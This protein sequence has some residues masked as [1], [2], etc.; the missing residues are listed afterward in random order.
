MS[1]PKQGPIKFAKPIGTPRLQQALLEFGKLIGMM[2]DAGSVNFTWF[3]S[4]HNNSL[5]G[6]ANNRDHLSFLLRALLGFPAGDPADML[7]ADLRWEP[8]TIISDKLDAGLLWNNTG[9]SMRLG[10]GGRVSLGSGKQ[11]VDL[12]LIARLLSFTP[13]GNF[14][15]QVDTEFGQFRVAGLLP[16][17]DFLDGAEIGVEIND[18][19]QQDV[20]HLGLKVTASGENTQFDVPNPEIVWD[21]ARLAILVLRAWV[22]SKNGGFFDRVNNHLFPALGDPAG[23]IQPFPLIADQPGTAPNFDLWKNSIF[24]FQNNG[25]GALTFLWHLRALITGSESTD[26]FSGSFYFP[27]VGGES[28][29]Q[30]QALPGFP[31]YQTLGEYESA[32][33]PNSVFLGVTSPGGSTHALVLDLHNP[34]GTR[35]RIE[36]AKMNGTFSRPTLPSGND[37]TDLVNFAATFN[38]AN[39]GATTIEVADEAGAIAITLATHTEPNQPPQP[40]GGDYK[41]QFLLRS[42]GAV[43]FRLKSPM[44]PAGLELP[45]NIG[46]AD[47]A[48][49]FVGLANWVLGIAGPQDPQIQIVINALMEIV[50]KAI[51]NEPP[52]PMPLLTSLLDLIGSNNLLNFGPLALNLDNNVI[53]PSLSLGP[54]KPGD[55]GDMPIHLGKLVAEA[56]VNLNTGAFDHAKVA[57][58]DLRFGEGGGAGASSG[59]VGSLLPDTRQFKGFTVAVSV[60]SGNLSIT[61][62]GKIPLQ[63]TIG[64]LDL[65]GLL[66]DL[67]TDRLLVGV[68]L[69]FKLAVITVT[70][71]E[72]GVDFP[73]NGGLPSPFLHGLGLSM[74]IPAVKLAGMFAKIQNGNQEDYVGGAVV[75][76]LSLFQLSAIGGYTQIVGDPKK[77]P[78]PSMFIFASLVAPLGG[79]PWFFI[80]GIAGGF[81]YNRTLPPPGLLTEH[82]F[83][84]VMRGDLPLGADAASSLA[85]L[86]T[87]FAAVAGQHWVAAGIQFTA[88]GFI[89]GKLVVAIA[90]GNKFAIQVLG[91]AAFGIEKIAY[92]EIGIEASANEEEFKLKAGLSK[93][94]YLVHPD[95]FSLTGEFALGVWHGG[96]HAGDFVFSIGGYHPY[97]DKP[98]HYDSLTKV[99]VRCVVYGFLRLTVECF[100]ACTPQALMAGASVSLSAE[101]A[102]IGCGL[103]VYF[104]VFIQWDPFYIRATLGIALWFE[105]FGRHEIG[106]DLQIWTPPFGGIATIDLALVSFDVDFGSELAPPPPPEPYEF[107]STH[108]QIPAERDGS[109][110]K[111]AA[112]NTDDVA[113]LF[114]VD[115]TEGRT[116]KPQA[117]TPKQEG[118]GTP[119]PM[120][121][122]FAFTVKTRLPLDKGFVVDPG[123]PALQGK[124]NLPL[125]EKFNLGTNFHVTFTNLDLSPKIDKFLKDM[126]PAADFGDK[127]TAAQSGARQAVAGVKTDQP[128]IALWDGYSLRCEAWLGAA[129]PAITAKGFEDSI[130]DEEE[131]PLPL[132]LPAGVPAPSAIANSRLTFKSGA[133]FPVIQVAGAKLSSRDQAELIIKNWKPLPLKITAWAADCQ[134]FPI[135]VRL[136]GLT[137]AAPPPDAPVIGVPSS[138]PRRVELFP[139]SL[140]I[141]TPKAT[142]DLRRR[143]LDT[144]SRA[145]NLKKSM[146]TPSTGTLTTFKTSVSVAPGTVQLLELEGSQIKGQKLTFS[147]SQAVR[148]VFLG[149]G[150]DFLSEAYVKGTAAVVPPAD[151]RQVALFGEGLYPAVGPPPA[152]TAPDAI[153]TLENVG[154][155]H[156]TT[157]TALGT[158]TLAAHG[159]VLECRTRL[160]FAVAPLDAVPG[161]EV[162]RFVKQMRLN[163]PAAGAGASL[164]ITVAPLVSNPGSAL[165]QV[166]WVGIGASLSDLTTIVGPDSTAFVMAAGAAGPWRLEIDLGKKWRLV[167]VVLMKQSGRDSVNLLRSKIERDLIDDRFQKSAETQPSAVLL[168]VTQ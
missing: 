45:P 40:F 92:F 14:P 6:I 69:S 127:V 17:P 19:A 122:E 22:A 7:G 31:G 29:Q 76:V 167:Q 99:G 143:R 58:Y 104:D 117:D 155:E 130:G 132:D 100:F 141:L 53:A 112:F 32:Q 91:L 39:A 135:G 120:A 144:L 10:V 147:G 59:I 154:I 86:G 77:D 162:L 136:R 36:I 33:H 129:P 43:A 140:R 157:L 51:R 38:G 115:F 12:A 114:R 67:R 165:D 3:M 18:P 21:C 41:L 113:G 166:R 2:D 158:R 50:G 164:V 63:E 11:H 42:G 125:C 124:I 134:R 61:G 105:F 149:A 88:F 97:F 123:V 116:T 75:R 16:V 102:G 81:G 93:N 90:F 25:E 20:F 54:F 44:A 103:D 128:S 27:I 168:E 79:P 85:S 94:S 9:N 126:F 37:W 156:D 163:F 98:K 133:N 160:P 106:V 118:I 87:Y 148:A 84:Q 47:Q 66:I 121:S 152:A 28:A 110:A 15:N 70:A 137:V 1:A 65:A 159:C 95:I 52:D 13:N 161:F 80:T 145:R 73:F 5:N 26:L 57:L 68:D 142:T 153:A 72:L 111:V 30:P 89:N 83:I 109:K 34:A 151:A 4:P 55:L 96:P 108:L 8:I 60:D 64:P 78:M 62:K 74:D 139:V 107:I 46:P 71:Y 119:V 23:P 56:G 82:P 48:T 35:K 131:Y 101:F 150:D 146:L 138:P 24:Q 49:L